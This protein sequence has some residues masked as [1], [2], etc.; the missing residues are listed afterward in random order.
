MGKGP[1]CILYSFENCSSWKTA[2]VGITELSPKSVLVESELGHFVQF[3]ATVSVGLM[4]YYGQ[5]RST[6]RGF[7]EPACLFQLL[8]M[9]KNSYIALQG[10]NKE[11]VPQVKLGKTL[12]FRDFDYKCS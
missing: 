5:F 9:E 11:P 8:N 4:S 2:A 7:M 10:T 6:W 1:A 3:W 12:N